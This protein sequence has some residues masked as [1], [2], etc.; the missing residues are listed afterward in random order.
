M[1]I[2]VLLSMDLDQT[3]NTIQLFQNKCVVPEKYIPTPRKVT[4]NSEEGR[5]S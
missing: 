1:Q 2:I 4:G 5:G 3:H